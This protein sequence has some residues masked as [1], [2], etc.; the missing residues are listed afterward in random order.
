MS[1]PWRRRSGRGWLRSSIH[2]TVMLALFA[3]LLSACGSSLNV[4]ETYPLES[5]SGSGS[6]TS[7]VYRAAGETVQEVAAALEA[8]KNPQQV[9]KEDP[10]HMFLVYADQI[11]HVQKDPN[12]AAD[13]LVEVDSKEYVRQNYSPS[14]LE[15]YLLASLIGNLF[16]SSRGGYYGDYR[17]YGSQ[18]S[19]PPTTGTYRT[20]TVSDQ[21]VAPPLTVDKKGSIFKRGGKSDSGSSV[22][23]DGLFG[24]KKSSTG[25][26][27]RDGTS[28][29]G[30]KS[31]SSFKPRKTTKPRTSFGGSGRIRRR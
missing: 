5:V 14:F 28:G 18:K 30:S 9:S 22:G 11:I 8:K 7:Y 25:S 29:S 24:K 16:D 17:G 4:Q 31:G 21:K 13:S 3:T 23:S 27:T 15:G 20:P 19:Y 1:R 10:D 2:L 12:N 26:I 6:Q